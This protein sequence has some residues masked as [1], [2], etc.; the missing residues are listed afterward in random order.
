MGNLL[1]QE[2]SPYL[3]QHAD[4]PVDWRPWGQA[5]FAQAREQDKPVLVSIGYATCHW[6][7]VMAH[8]SFEDQEVAELLNRHFVAIKVDREERPD[9]DHLYMTVCQALTGGGGW[10]LNVFLTPEGKPFY[11]GTYFPK[12]TRLGRPG[13]MEVLAYLAKLWREDRDRL[14]QAGEQIIAA[15]QPRV[16]DPSAEPLGQSALQKAARQLAGAF[17]PQYG[18]F[19]KAPKFPSPHQLTFLLRWHHRQGDAKALEMVVKTLKAMRQGG[20]Y[21]QV[22]YGFH[23]Y[24]VDAYW[25]VP[26]FEKMLYD[27]AGL[28][29]A[30]LEAFQVTGDDFHARVAREIFEYVLRDMT[31]ADGGF[32]SAEDADSEGHEGTFYVWTPAQV[33]KVLGPELAELFC[34]YYDVSEAGNF[35]GKSIPHVTRTPQALA[36]QTGLEPQEVAARLEDARGRLFEAREQRQ[37]P[38]KDDK[39]LTAW[40]GLMIAAL[41]KGAAVLGDPAYLKAA[42]RAAEFVLERLRAPDGRLWRRWRLG[43]AA[44]RGC[45][46]DYAFMVWGLLE[47]YQAGHQVAHLEKALE[48]NRTC[49]ELFWD[50]DSGGF[51]FTPQG[52]E[53]LLVRDKDLYDGATPSGNSAAL[54]NLL[55]LGRLTGQGDLEERADTMLRV[56]AAQAGEHPMAFCHLM[57]AVDFAQGPS[58]EVVVAGPEGQAQTERMLALLKTDFAPRRVLLF[59][60]GGEAGRALAELAPFVAGMSSADGKPRV[61]I[62]SDYACQRPLEDPQELAAALGQTS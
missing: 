24:S 30:Y 50:H 3:L 40:N 18:G 36:R 1:S 60:P 16:G 44:H 43:E 41:A 61:Y 39:V 2:K 23:R 57:S 14:L 6:C 31:D 11:A 59:N 21:D 7:H 45:L 58:Q 34:R 8:E 35:E 49:L 52:D 15:I 29:L 42:D 5:A 47:L 4:N 17:D 54:C 56:F 38:L 37:H 13:F 55:R 53:Q 25:L 48:L 22:G 9:V 12:H 19:G 20:M 28:A 10:P 62:C 26:H 51:F 33:Q 27:Q 46:E 32:Y